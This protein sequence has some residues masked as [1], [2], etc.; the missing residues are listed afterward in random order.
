MSN[1][2]PDKKPPPP[3]PAPRSGRLQFS[4]LYC[5][6][7]WYLLRDCKCIEGPMRVD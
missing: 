4:D 6:R 1:P 3:P 5:Y 2:I 7:C